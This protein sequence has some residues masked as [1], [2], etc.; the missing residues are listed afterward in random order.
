VVVKT[1]VFVVDDNEERG[2]AKLLI[3]PDGVES[4]ADED[5]PARRCD[6]DADRWRRR[7]CY[8]GI[9]P[10]GVARLDE[11]VG[12]ELIVLAGG[13]EIVEESEVFALILEPLN[14]WPWSNRV[15]DARIDIIFAEQFE[16]VLDMPSQLMPCLAA[17]GSGA[18]SE[19]AIGKRR[20]G[21][22]E[23]SDRNGELTRK[24]VR[25]GTFSGLKH[26]MMRWAFGE[27]C[28]LPS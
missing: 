2:F 7:K 14:S 20:T 10:V 21:T 8:G 26:F 17:D 3:L 25:T 11:A 13:Q 6:R 19:G 9:F 18:V 24:L 5:S 1:A 28:V 27:L 12:G 15:E 16:I 22:E 4:V 23:N